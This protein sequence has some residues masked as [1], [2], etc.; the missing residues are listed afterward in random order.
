MR[1]KKLAQRAA[2]AALAACMMFTLSAPALAESTNALMQMSINSRSSIARLNEE[3]SIPEDAVTL[4]IRNGNIR[5]YIDTDGKQYVVQGNGSPE[6]CSALVVSGESTQY[7][8]TITGDGSAAANVYLNNLKIT[9]SD[10]AVS[11]SGDVVLI[12]EGESELHSGKNHAGVEKANDNGTLT[13][14]GS[15][16]LS[17]YGGE[18]GAGI[19]GASGKP[20]NNITINGGTITASGK[21]GDGW[22]AGIGGGKGQGGSNITIRGGN[23]KAI[24]GAEAA[25]IGGGFKGNGTDISIEGGT[26]YAESG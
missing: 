13:I 9:S 4:D 7:N 12:V 18:G 2:S 22:G 26:V 5:V 3:N 24:P 8:L 15:G 20:G 16:K 25:G 21:A 19:G 6:E 23:V 10:A 1:Q 17:A 14:T 11:V